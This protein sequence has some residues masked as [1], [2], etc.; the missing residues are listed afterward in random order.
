MADLITCES[1]DYRQQGVDI[2]ADIDWRI[3]PGQHWAVLGPNG[4]GKTTLLRIACGY[5]WPTR[6]RVLRLGQEL[7][8]LGELRR[9]IGWIS[10]AMIA[11]IP[12]DDT[13]LETVVSGRLAQFGLKH[14]P[15]AAPKEADFTDAAAEL[16]RLG[17][18]SLAEKPFGV[19]SQGERQQVLIARARMARPLLLVLDEPCA[20]MDPGVRE[21]FLSWL[22]ERLVSD[23]AGPTTIFVTHH[24]EEIVPGIQNTL[25]L[26]SGRVHSA[27][28][29]GEVITRDAIESVY[30]TRLARIER[31]GCRLW[32]IWGS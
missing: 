6:G 7:I 29:T 5:L 24:I 11:D 18:E 28:T 26:S 30:T 1:V 13:G 23:K 12:P 17:C 14:L 25:I 9:G 21:R 31:S 2:L 19:L 16:K 10:S 15:G 8:D 32:P 4:S 3:E 20:G 27:G 22:H